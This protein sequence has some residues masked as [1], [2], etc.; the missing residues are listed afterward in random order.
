M[1]P[2]P[3]FALTPCGPRATAHSCFPSV[4]LSPHFP[5]P[6]SPLCASLPPGFAPPS[7]PSS[8][9]RSDR[10]PARVLLPAGLRHGAA[11]LAHLPAGE[12]RAWGLRGQG[13]WLGWGIEGAG[14]SRMRK[15]GRVG[16]RACGNADVWACAHVTRLNGACLQMGERRSGSECNG[17]REHDRELSDANHCEPACCCPTTTAALPCLACHPSLSFSLPVSHRALPLAH[18]SPPSRSPSP[19]LFPTQGGAWCYSVRS[20]RRRA[21]TLLGSSSLW[22]HPSH[23]DFN[24]QVRRSPFALLL[25]SHALVPPHALPPQYSIFPRTTSGPVKES[26]TGSPCVQLCLPPMQPS[27]HQR[28]TNGAQPCAML[29]GG[30]AGVIAIPLSAHRIRCVPPY[31]APVAVEAAD[32]VR[33]GGHAARTAAAR[34][35]MPSPFPPTHC[36]PPLRRQLKR[37]T[38]YGMDGMLHVS[39]AVNPRFFNWHVVLI[40]YCDGAAFS[41]TRGHFNASRSASLVAGGRSILKSV[42]RRKCFTPLAPHCH[43]HFP[44][45]P[46]NPPVLSALN[47]VIVNARTLHI[48]SVVVHWAG[49]T[50]GRPPARPQRGAAHLAARHLSSGAAPSPP[51]HLP[52][53]YSFRITTCAPCLPISPSLLPPSPGGA[54]MRVARG[55]KGAQRVVVAGCSAGAQAVAMQCDALARLLPTAAAKRC[56]MDGGFFPGAPSCSPCS[57]CM[58]GSRGGKEGEKW[59]GAGVHP[60]PEPP[61]L[62]N[63]PCPGEGPDARWRCFFPEHGL[64]YVTTPL[65]LVNSVNDADAIN[66]LN[67]HSPTRRRLRRCLASLAG[68][69]RGRCAKEDVGMALAYAIR[70]A[71]LARQVA[72]QNPVVKPFLY[73]ERMHCA[74]LVNRWSTVQGDG[75]GLRDVLGSWAMR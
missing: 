66:L 53:S 47:P 67:L 20:C 68:G 59:E 22:P 52:L 75:G 12:R 36:V 43:A 23:P 1:H 34:V 28:E 5:F 31:G 32:G 38:G 17:T 27:A 57:P 3:H 49:S 46:T 25:P 6:D 15:C 21:L 55:M 72:Q 29:R 7:L 41:G 71:G 51:P 62:S 37:L 69:S 8:R 33:H 24:T 50:A 74:T 10:Q 60:P 19:F 45:S 61:T 44:P 13:K 14:Y 70:V 9:M 40:A 56:I 35:V 42:I 11:Q 26:V 54:D 2:R 64:R 58:Q 30:S 16:M 73:R 4:A 63:C 18:H 48:P 65:L 39:A